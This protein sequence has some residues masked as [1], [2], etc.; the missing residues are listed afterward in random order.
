MPEPVLHEITIGDG[1]DERRI[2]CLTEDGEAPGIFWLQGFKSDMVS[3]KATALSE[4][5]QAKGLAY[6]RF[7][8]S[9]HGQSGGAFEEGTIGKWLDEAQ[10]VFERFTNGPQI[11][12]GSSMGGHLALL[13]ARRLQSIGDGEKPGRIEGIVLIAPAWDMTEELMWKTASAEARRAIEEDG[14]WY[15]PSDYGEPYAITRGLIEEGRNHLFAAKPWNPGC[16]VE[17]IHGRLD[18]DVPYAHSERLVAF[19]KDQ[20]VNLTEVPDGEHRLSRPEDLE[21]LFAKIGALAAA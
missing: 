21:L 12:V 19:L 2:A 18:P 10:S 8:Y 15:R 16:P 20:A 9:G 5:T 14:V 1:P 4:W 17:I 13:L 3:T 6:T 7:D 11:V